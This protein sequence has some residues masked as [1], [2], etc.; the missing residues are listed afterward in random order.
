MMVL[1][2]TLPIDWLS[3]RASTPDVVLRRYGD[4]GALAEMVRSMKPGDEIRKFESPRASWKKR[5]GRF[6]YALVRGGK[7]VSMVVIR[8]N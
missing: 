2:Y 6:G 5:A 4:G 7:P 8:L 1:P 3:G